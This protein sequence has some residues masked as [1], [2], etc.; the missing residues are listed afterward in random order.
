MAEK[1]VILR[2]LPTIFKHAESEWYKMQYEQQS[3]QDIG[4]HGD[5]WPVLT[6]K[7]EYNIFI[8]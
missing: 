5:S 6:Y 3:V 8:I 1:F 2:T 4:V 7:G